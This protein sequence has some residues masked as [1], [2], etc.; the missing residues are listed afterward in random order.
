MA[1]SKHLDDVNLFVLIAQA[2][3]LNAAEATTRLPRS[4]LSRR[5]ARLEKRLGTQLAKRSPHSF[6]LTPTGQAYF[7]SCTAAIDS[8]VR[9]E[10]EVLAHQTS[11]SGLVRITAAAPL[12]YAFLAVELPDFL[13][14]HPD[15]FVE[16]DVEGQK[17][18]LATEAYDIAFR[19]GDPK[20]DGQVARK[21]FEECEAVYVAPALLGDIKVERPHDLEQ[22]PAIGCRRDMS[23]PSRIQWSLTNGTD[24]LQVSL[25]VRAS[26]HDGVA[27]L[28]LAERGAGVVSIPRFIAAPAVE[29][30]TL[31]RLLPDWTS[32]PLVV[33]AILPQRPTAATKAI[34]RHLVDRVKRHWV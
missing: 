19:V 27:A 2:G 7:D 22:F 25:R 33:R 16:I 20:G 4:A 18:N 31:V 34:L 15:I 21:M 9:A 24:E 5:L 6:M 23:S 1:T 3:G 11:L 8:I 29:A 30:G 26:V 28:I 17:V 10:S 12:T 13:A 14:E 32:P